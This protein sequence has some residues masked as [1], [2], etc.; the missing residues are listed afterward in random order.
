MTTLL[1]LLVATLTLGFFGAP[2]VGWAAGYALILLWTG[3]GAFG[4]T[5]F[6]IFVALFFTPPVRRTLLS[7]PL[8]GFLKKA[9]ILPSI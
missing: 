5:M 1:L 2:A 6:G 9:G 7:K 4:W 3:A 8:M